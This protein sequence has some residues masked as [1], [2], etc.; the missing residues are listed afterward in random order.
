MNTNARFRWL[1]GLLGVSVLLIGASQRLQLSPVLGV[2]IGCS[3][4]V[5]YHL[6]ILAPRQ[7]GELGQADV[8][9]VYYFGFLVTIVSLG[10]GVYYFRSAGKQDVQILLRQF[11]VGIMATAYAVFARMHIASLRSRV[12]VVDAQAM[13]D[14]QLRRSED[15]LQH[16]MAVS[17]QAAALAS[18]LSGARELVVQ[19][20]AEEMSAVLSN[21]AST[22]AQQIGTALTA[23]QDITGQVQHTL[24]AVSTVLV[25]QSM[26]NSLRDLNV[27]AKA[28]GENS[29]SAASASL[30]AATAITMVGQEFRG[31][32]GTLSTGRDELKVVAEIVTTL[33]EFDSAASATAASVGAAGAELVRVA[34]ELRDVGDAVSTAP[35]TMKRLADQV[36]RTADGIDFLAGV[37]GKIDTAAAGLTNAA[38]STERLSSALDHLVRVAPQVAVGLEQVQTGTVD[39]ARSLEQ[40]VKSVQAAGVAVS[41]LEVATGSLENSSKG[42][43]DLASA[44]ND[45]L[46]G[47]VALSEQTLKSQGQVAASSGQFSETTRSAAAALQRDMEAATSSAAQVSKRLVD[48]VNTIV[49]QTR[50]QQSVRP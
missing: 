11:A 48:L 49:E 9:S 42:F 32:Q 12:E 44:A 19:R 47:L 5:Y 7:N 10:F 30:E 31:L 29:T 35:R 1:S 25:D 18:S 23:V 38:E 40:L 17:I 22:F 45:L 21:I 41:K 4:L 8:D 16:M 39:S 15:V 34:T 3:P 20:S 14:Q 13:L 2:L 37:A 24:S 50:R 27:A 36:S 33:R 6:R 43:K 26:A 28:L 46:Q